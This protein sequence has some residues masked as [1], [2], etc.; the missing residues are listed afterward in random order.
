MAKKLKNLTKNNFAKGRQSLVIAHVCL[1]YAPHA[2]DVGY[3]H[4]PMPVFSAL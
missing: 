2:Q 4:N 3:L 1:A